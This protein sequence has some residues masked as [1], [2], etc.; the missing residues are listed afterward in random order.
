[1]GQREISGGEK[2]ASFG[3]DFED[4]FG[5]MQYRLADVRNK[6]GKEVK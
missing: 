3:L 5:R 1:M 2:V 6:E 4:S